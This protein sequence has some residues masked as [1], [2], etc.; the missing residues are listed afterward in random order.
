MAAFPYL[1]AAS[2]GVQTVSTLLSG[3]ARARAMRENARI[4]ALSGQIQFEQA[5]FQARFARKA[6]AE[7]AQQIRRTSRRTAGALTTRTAGS[8]VEL[9]GSPLLSIAD[10]IW[11]DERAAGIAIVNAEAGATSIEARGRAAQVTG[12]AESSRL[13]AEAGFTETAAWLSS[14]TTAFR[15]YAQYRLMTGGPGSAPSDPSGGSGWDDS[16]LFE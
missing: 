5:Q 7:H 16:M 11:E 4:A 14:F 12:E 15:G 10:Q 13:R 2:V 1:F 8:G 3:R 9:R 6:G